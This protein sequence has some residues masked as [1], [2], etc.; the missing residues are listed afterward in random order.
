MTVT[1]IIPDSHPIPTHLH[2]SFDDGIV[3]GR[4]QKG[5]GT[6]GVSYGA[7]K[8]KKRRK[9]IMT[10]TEYLGTPETVL[11]RELAFGVLRVRDSPVVVH[12]R[13]VR[14]L[15]IALTAF[16]R[17]HRL[18]EIL[19]APMDVILDADANLVVQPDIVFVS[20]ERASIISDRIYG[21]PD[22]VVEVL[23]PHPRIGR[24]HEK[25]EWFA[26]YGVKE[27]WLVDLTRREIAVLAFE[28]GR[29]AGRGLFSDSERIVSAVLPGLGLTPFALF[30]YQ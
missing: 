2:L 27:C 14:D 3:V 9:N 17:D 24:L 6:V 16:T 29:V 13:V 11:P 20:T 1:P 19:P 28:G 5:S 15:T 7:V 25:V 21:T 18:G 8:N 30:G 10:T 22:L 12:Q 26:R 23:S 4:G